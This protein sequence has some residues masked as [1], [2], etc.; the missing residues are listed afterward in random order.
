M[1]DAKRIEI[2][3]KRT[4]KHLFVHE[5]VDLT[6]ANVIAAITAAA[7]EM[8]TVADPEIHAN[9]ENVKNGILKSFDAID[10]EKVL[11]LVEFMNPNTVRAAIG[12]SPDYMD[13]SHACAVYKAQKREYDQLFGLTN[14]LSLIDENNKTL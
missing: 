7:R 14:E 3:I 5:D 4:A 13:F 10:N 9:K 11:N 1:N 2:M 12:F 6:K 8:S